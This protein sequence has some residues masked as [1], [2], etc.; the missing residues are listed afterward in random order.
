MG[1]NLGD[2]K[3]EGDCIQCPFHHW[4]FNGVDGRC[5]DIPYSRDIKI[6]SQ[7]K[8]RVWLSHEVHGIVF[9]WHHAENKKPWSFPELP[10]IER[11]CLR[12]Q[13][14]NEYFV[15]CHIQDIPENGADVS[16]LKAVH[17]EVVFVGKF[18]KQLA[19][20]SWDAK[21]QVSEIPYIATLK[22]RH[23]LRILNNFEILALSIQ[24]KQIGPAF[25]QLSMTSKAGVFVCLQTVTPIHGMLQRVIHRFYRFV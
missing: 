8:I 16:H 21:W 4:K 20:H 23:S 2:G 9:I 15:K 13:G 17:E 11:N 14:R 6:P 19:K 5:V 12:F 10:E 18:V 1:A 25:V 3:V 7:A 24:T 22:M